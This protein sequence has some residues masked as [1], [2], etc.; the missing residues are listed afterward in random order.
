MP[1]ARR[2]EVQ[3]GARHVLARVCPAVHNT[4][5]QK[6]HERT[7]QFV[8]SVWLSG[9]SRWSGRDCLCSGGG[10]LFDGPALVASSAHPQQHRRRAFVG[11]FQFHG[12]NGTTF[13]TNRWR[14]SALVGHQQTEFYWSRD[15]R[16]VT[17]TLTYFCPAEAYR[18]YRIHR[19]RPSRRD[20]NGRSSTASRR[21]FRR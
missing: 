12:A 10:R 19:L 8:R 16:C 11:P 14:V 7:T 21:V 5:A 1:G 13:R 18:A 4:L 3:G 17:S 15:A 6:T 20:C 9:T 2:R